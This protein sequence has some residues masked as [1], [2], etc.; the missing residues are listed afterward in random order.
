MVRKG[1]QKVTTKQAI[2]LDL[3]RKN[4]S[5]SRKDIAD[6]LGINESAIQKHLDVLKAKGVIKRVGPDKGG[7]WEVL[8]SYI[9]I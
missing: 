8:S 3:I 6:K 1:G 5:M 4:P 9:R 2:V 7:H